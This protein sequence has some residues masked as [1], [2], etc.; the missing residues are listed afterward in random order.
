MKGKLEDCK[1][2]LK[3]PAVVL[4]CEFTLK[5]SEN[6]EFIP[7]KDYGQICMG[8]LI[9]VTFGNAELGQSRTRMILNIM[10]EII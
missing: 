5:P 9:L 8:V 10:E 3:S 7:E 1:P 4:K 6:G 2:A